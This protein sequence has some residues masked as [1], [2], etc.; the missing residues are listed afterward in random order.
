MKKFMLGLAAAGLIV[1]GCATAPEKVAPAY[2]S[3]VQFANYDC[4][5]IRVEL[6]RVSHRVTEVSG[7]Q[8]KKRNQD[9]AAVA[10]GV[11]IFWPALFFLMSD[12]NKAELSRL[13]GEYE[14]LN[15]TAVEKKCPVAEEIAA[16]QTGAK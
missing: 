9:T 1:S 13:K 12:D 5:Q 11:V 15:R 16:A 4:D 8:R 14:A 2:V 3:P 10:V 6:E 7:Q